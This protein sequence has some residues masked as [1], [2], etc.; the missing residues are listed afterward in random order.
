M[1]SKPGLVIF[2]NLRLYGVIL[3]SK[4]DFSIA[5]IPR[6]EQSGQI[7][8]QA[9]EEIIVE[10]KDYVQIGKAA[11]KAAFFVISK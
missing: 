9:E 6:A 3:I 10:W 2:F 4:A 7:G 5:C 11:Q 1:K 8:D